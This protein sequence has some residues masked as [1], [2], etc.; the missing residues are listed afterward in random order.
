MA[1]DEVESKVLAEPLSGKYI[2]G[3]KVVKVIVV[4]GKIVNIVV[5]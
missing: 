4:P 5:K 2:G 1:K 3:G